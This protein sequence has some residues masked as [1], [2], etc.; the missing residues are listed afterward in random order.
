MF[1]DAGGKGKPRYA[2]VQ[3]CFAEDE[4][5]AKKTALEWFPNIA[6]PGEL[7]QEL[8]VPAH[9]EQSAELLSPDDLAETVACGPDPDRHVEMIERFTDAGYDNVYVHQIGPDQEAFFD[10]YRREVLPRFS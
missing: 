10:F 1:D 3:V 6:L 2:Q 5:E 7:S 9:F 8:P 4:D